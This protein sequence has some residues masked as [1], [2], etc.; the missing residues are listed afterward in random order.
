MMKENKVG[1]FTDFYFILFSEC[2][3]IS[4]LFIEKVEM[5]YGKI[6]LTNTLENGSVQINC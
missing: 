4:D 5:S 3:V 2:W 6:R 1:F